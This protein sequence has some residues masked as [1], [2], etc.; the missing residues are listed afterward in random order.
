MHSKESL[1]RQKAINK[2]FNVILIKIKNV[3]RYAKNPIAND[4]TTT[5]YKK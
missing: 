1:G 5:L 3:P 4:W 2:I